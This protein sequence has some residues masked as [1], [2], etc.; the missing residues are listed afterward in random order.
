M[1]NSM[2][3]FVESKIGVSTP[4]TANTPV[5]FRC[6]EE[7]I[8]KLDELTTTLGFSSRSKLLSELVPIAIENALGNLPE[9]MQE[10]FYFNTQRKI[11]ALHEFYEDQRLLP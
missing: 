5:S 11:E 4:K 9:D 10:S 3:E 6:S 2:R 1:S 8:I 7:E